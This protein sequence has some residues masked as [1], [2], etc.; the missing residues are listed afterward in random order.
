MRD[1]HRFHGSDYHYNILCACRQTT[2]A[3]LPK[4][5]AY[6]VG[7]PDQFQSLREMEQ[8]T[9]Y[10]IRMT[11]DGVLTYPAGE[12]GGGGAEEQGSRGAREQEKTHLRTHAQKAPPH[13]P[14]RT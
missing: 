6:V 11:A 3:E 10:L 8:G 13:S 5:G 14:R 9:G 12:L 7:L 4:R 2:H 1:D